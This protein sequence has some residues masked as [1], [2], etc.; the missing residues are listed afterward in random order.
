M[1][2]HPD[3]LA[4]MSGDATAPYVCSTLVTGGFVYRTLLWAGEYYL[5]NHHQYAAI[6]RGETPESLG[7]DPERHEED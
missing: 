7:L 1:T 5:V 6:Q 4:R 3:H 2:I